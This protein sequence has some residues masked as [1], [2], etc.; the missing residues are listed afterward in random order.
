MT[1]LV[2]TTKALQG[3]VCFCDDTQ[4]ELISAVY[5]KEFG[6]ICFILRQIRTG[7]IVCEYIEK[8]RLCQK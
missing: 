2:E 4:C 3:K 1:E 6:R 5:E 8:V 7:K